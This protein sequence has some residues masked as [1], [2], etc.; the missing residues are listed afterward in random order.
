MA[1]KGLGSVVK[2][3]FDALFRPQRFVEFQTSTYAST[4]AENVRQA[5]SLFGVYLVNLVA[6][7]IPLTLAGI[8]VQRSGQPPA[9]YTALVGQF[10][11]S[12]T[13][14]W[15]LLTAFVLNSL[16]ITTAAGLTLVTFHIGLVLARGSSGV[17]QS[18]HTVVYTT[19]A[20]L[21]A[22]FSGVWYLTTGSGV[23]GARELVRNLQAAFVYAI[24]DRLGVSLELPGGRPGD[25][26]VGSISTTGRWALAL[27][28]IA[29]GY[30]LV[31][32]YLGARVNHLASKGS[33]ALAV[34]AVI[35]SPVV[36]VT[37]SVLAVTIGVA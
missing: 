19:S 29:L 31:S 20:Y 37:A 7:A 1:T 5:G 32:L 21:A 6:Y 9:G 27:L 24:I 28:V 2:G 10:G 8:G 25:I 36:Y 13:A 4:R 15:Q 30:Y 11:L 22:V 16:Y 23:A 12:P 17:V 18:V 14:S 33:A 3:V 26:F 35:L 34:C